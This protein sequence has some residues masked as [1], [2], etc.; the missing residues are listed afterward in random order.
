MKFCE[1]FNAY[2]E[3]LGC[4]AKELT[5]YSGLS[6]ATLSRYRSGERVP[7]RGSAAMEKLCTA[8]AQAAQRRG[9]GELT[10]EKVRQRF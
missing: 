8:V 2:L 4:T 1:A 5:E 9:Y 6:A 3:E 10:S 7:E